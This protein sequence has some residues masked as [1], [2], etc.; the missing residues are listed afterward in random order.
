MGGLQPRRRVGD[1]VSLSFGRSVKA[2]LVGAR[3]GRPSLDKLP[4]R[5]VS[6]DGAPKGRDPTS[7]S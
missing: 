3:D 4:S 2:T 6:V 7:Y 1:Q 5:T